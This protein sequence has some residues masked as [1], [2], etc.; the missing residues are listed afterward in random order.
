MKAQTISIYWTGG[1]FTSGI[2]A[3]KVLRDSLRLQ[4]SAEI[5]ELNPRKDTLVE[6]F[7][8]THIVMSVAS[9]SIVVK[10]VKIAS[11]STNRRMAE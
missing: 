10:K 1:T 2:L 5:L 6:V 8:G 3:D 4:N 7:R 11:M 9:S